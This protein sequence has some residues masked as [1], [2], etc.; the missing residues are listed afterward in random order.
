MNTKQLIAFRE[1]MLTGSISE[2]SRNLHRTQP[3]ISSQIKKLEEAI[4][5]K[6]FARKDGR[7]HPLPEAQFL[8]HQANEI[9][10]RLNNVQDTLAKIRNLESGTIHIVAMPG[11]SVFL[12]PQL[13]GDFLGK[14]DDV[15]ISL[16]SRSSFQVQQL[17]SA[18]SYD[19]GLADI[20]SGHQ[21]SSLVHHDILHFKCFCAIPANDPLAQK[22]IITA[23]DLDNKPMATLMEEHD[24]TIQLTNIFKSQG[25]TLKKRFETQYFIPQLTFVEQGLAYAI[26][27]PLSIESYNLYRQENKRIIFKPFSPAMSFS[28]SL[29]TPSHRPLSNI[30]TAFT[31]FLKER[32]IE[33]QAKT[34]NP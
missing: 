17:V 24:T 29:V 31:A 2:A 5:L 25:L 12:L 21:D 20:E 14:R 26:I 19:I 32:L 10:E 8:L 1:V 4:D 15:N 28:V 34:L 23:K 27:D 9:L 7:L 18:Q 6:L 3:A 30:A 33:L 16:I 13:V 22:K 11:P